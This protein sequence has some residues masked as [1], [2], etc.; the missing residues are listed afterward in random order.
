MENT[1]SES[2]LENRP[3]ENR[4]LENRPLEN[5]PLTENIG[6]SESV[7]LSLLLFFI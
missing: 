1:G 2:L 3:L 5:R 7:E 6:A 4:P